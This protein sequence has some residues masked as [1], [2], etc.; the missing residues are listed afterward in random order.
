MSQILDKPKI[1]FVLPSLEAGGAERVFI[2]LLNGLDEKDYDRALLSIQSGGALENLV[3]PAISVFSL[4]QN[5]S[6]FSLPKLFF[7]IKKIQ[8]DVVFSTMLHMNF[9]VLALKPFFPKIKFIVR[10]AIT[11]SYLF[12][13]HKSWAFIIKALYKGLYPKITSCVEPHK[14][15]V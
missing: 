10:E 14:H 6:P 2:T 4:D 3:D 9:A 11:P 15:G 1:L 12:E 7:M 13:K 5:L 8:P